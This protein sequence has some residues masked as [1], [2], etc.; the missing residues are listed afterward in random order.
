MGYPAC[1][2]SC[3][4]LPVILEG[5][6]V[7][8]VVLVGASFL[9]GGVLLIVGVS[10]HLWERWKVFLAALDSR[11]WATTT[12][13][14]TR[15]VVTYTMHRGVRSYAPAV[16]YTYNA[17]GASF[18][19]ER[20]A[21][22]ETGGAGDECEAATRAV[23]ERFRAGSE[24]QVYYDPKEPSRATLDRSVPPVIG[25]T[26]GWLAVMLLGGG[27]MFSLG[28][29][30]VRGPFEDPPDLGDAPALGVQL[31]GVAVAVG[32][33]LM[34][35]AAVRALGSVE[36]RGRALLRRLRT[37]KTTLIRDVREGE[38]VT[39]AGTVDDS[40]DEAEPLTLPFEDA[41]LVYYDVDAQWFRRICFGTFD[42][43]DASGV[44]L[45]EIEEAESTLLQSRRLRI[46]GSVE[47]W[48]DEQLD[49]SDEPHDGSNERHDAGADPILAY[50]EWLRLECIRKGDPVIVIGQAER[51]EGELVIR[52]K[53]GKPT[54]LLVVDGSR[55]E[56][57][58]RLGARI[59]KTRR[60]FLAGGVLLVMGALA[61]M[62]PLS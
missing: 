61:M 47:R 62:M 46:E 56:V 59:G 19:S 14:I 17:G 20:Y 41:P 27:V 22:V 35:V 1:A 11:H 30:V 51:V 49:E 16:R 55:E 31:G 12:G 58:Q 10:G 33:V 37:G 32:A 36:R 57:S 8:F 7:G 34:F 6:L 15:A 24:V 21:F 18:V 4:T 9:L 23:I 13:K 52:A 40:D 54:S 42:V 48:L 50:P 60:L 3:D 28:V 29:T 44:V 38:I 2:L 45:V 25:A 39:I 5:L 26:L 43:R 53:P